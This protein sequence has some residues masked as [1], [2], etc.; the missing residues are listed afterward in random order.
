MQ[1]NELL[2]FIDLVKNPDK[3]KAKVDELIAYNKSIEA[4][5]QLTED[6]AD[7]AK[8]KTLTAKALTEA[9]A[10]IDS[11]KI[12]AK[13]CVA[14]AQA[15]AAK[16]VSTADERR[17]ALETWASELKTRE[18]SFTVR[19]AALTKLESEV[20]DRSRQVEQ[21]RASLAV[22]LQEVAERLEKLKSVM[23]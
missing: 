21:D 6:I 8:A 15:Q 22:Q 20:A 16:L 2:E 23:G 14:E 7:I 10:Q 1:L 11:A 4:N 18:E 3:Y 19:S 5:I 17:V 12:E 13:R 9:L